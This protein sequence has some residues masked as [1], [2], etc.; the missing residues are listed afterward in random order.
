MSR[1]TRVITDPAAEARADW[2]GNKSPITG[3]CIMGCTSWEHCLYWPEEREAH[4]EAHFAAT[5]DSLRRERE[6]LNA[7][8]PEKPEQAE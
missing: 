7:N 1:S 6:A 4:K 2:C 3:E 5:R 8:P